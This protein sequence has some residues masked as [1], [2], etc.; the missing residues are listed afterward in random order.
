[1]QPRVAEIVWTQTV[2][3]CYE[4]LTIPDEEDPTELALPALVVMVFSQEV[5]VYDPIHERVVCNPWVLIKFDFGDCRFSN[6]I[7]QI[8]NFDHPLFSDLMPLFGRE[9]AW[10]YRAG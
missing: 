10:D 1:L 4:G 2:E 7:H 9:P 3:E 5:E 6:E 8:R